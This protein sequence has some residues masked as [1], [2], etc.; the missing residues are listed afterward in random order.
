P[1]SMKYGFSKSQLAKY[2][3]NLGIV[4]EHIP[5]L[6]IAS[7]K[8]QSLISEHDYQILF[9]GYIAELSEKQPHL[10]QIMD[11]MKAHPRIALTCFEKLPKDCH[12]H[13]VSDYLQEKH[14]LKCR[15]L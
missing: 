6:G 10:Y 8:R 9:D 7:Q 2:C 12:R 11:L 1:V 3:G 5:E 13:C 4:Y 15:H 14:L